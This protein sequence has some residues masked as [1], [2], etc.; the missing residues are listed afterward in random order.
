MSPL[1]RSRQAY[2]EVSSYYTDYMGKCRFEEIDHT[3]DLALLIQ[4]PDLPKL[5]D[6]ACRA[7]QSVLSLTFTG[8]S[9]PPSTLTIHAED[10]E[11]LLVRLLEEQLY[12]M[13]ASGHAWRSWE[14]HAL[15]PLE[16][17]V[18]VVLCP[19]AP[20]DIHIKAVTFHNLKIRQTDAGLETIVV[21]DV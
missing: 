13:D 16:F 8:P 1:Y 15:G 2:S 19:I 3:A 9:D 10:P 6:C 20:P 4:A 12:L 18:H 5:L 11:T 21:F 7:F 17:E 14:L